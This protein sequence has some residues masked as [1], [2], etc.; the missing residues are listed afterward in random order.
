MF[1]GDSG[2]RAPV[3]ALVYDDVSS[4]LAC[5]GQKNDL[6]VSMIVL[7]ERGERR[8]LWLVVKKKNL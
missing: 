6:Q 8:E 2:L 7:C 5:G 3:D 1:S 4:R